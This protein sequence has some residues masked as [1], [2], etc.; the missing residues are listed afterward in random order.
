LIF[1]EAE[2]RIEEGSGK[3]KKIRR[4]EAPT[5]VANGKMPS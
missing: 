5:V 2:F 1:F 4:R 3:E